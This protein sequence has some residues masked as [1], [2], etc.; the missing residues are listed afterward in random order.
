MC[1]RGRTEG[2]TGGGHMYVTMFCRRAEHMRAVEHL[3]DYR[4]SVLRTVGNKSILK[5]TLGFPN[6][7]ISPISP[8]MSTHDII[9][10]T[11]ATS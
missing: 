10:P 6:Q 7:V 9:V 3:M 11:G 5:G 2:G 4:Y 1:G 8:V